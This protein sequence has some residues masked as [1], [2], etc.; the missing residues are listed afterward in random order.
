MRAVQEGFIPGLPSG[1]P[2]VAVMGRPAGEGAVQPDGAARARPAARVEGSKVEGGGLM[3]LLGLGSPPAPAA[4]AAPA[5]PIE[6]AGEARGAAPG[7]AREAWGAAPL[8]TPHGM[9]AGI[10]A[11]VSG[12]GFEQSRPVS[13]GS[14]GSGG[15]SGMVVTSNT[16]TLYE[17]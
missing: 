8:A 14:S 7:E 15:G 3:A 12:T 1:A 2:T 17:A 9:E 10:T 16:P 11:G 13:A 4:P 6:A 5:A